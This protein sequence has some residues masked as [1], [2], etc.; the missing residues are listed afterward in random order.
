MKKAILLSVSLFITISALAQWKPVGDK[1]MSPW[2]EKVDPTNVHPE[3]PRPQMVRDQWMNLNGLWNYSITPKDAQTFTSEGKILVPF[4]VESAL[5]GVGRTVGDDNILWYEREFTVPASWKG[6]DVKL[7]FGAVDWETDVWVN[8]E[9]VGK[10]KGGFDP[11]SFNITSQLKKSGKQTLRVRVYDATDQTWQPRGKQVK[12][13]GLIWYTPVTGIW[14]TVWLEPVDRTHIEDYYIVSDVDKKTMSVDVQVAAP[15]IG[16]VVKVDIIEGG[17]GYSAENPSAKVIASA[18]TVNGKAVIT[19]PEINTWSPD[20]PYLYG[21]KVSVVRNSKVIDSVDGYTAMR[22]VSRKRDSSPCRYRRIA[23]NDQIIFQFGPLDQGWW[24][25]GLYTAPTDE[26][27][28]FDLI[29]TKEWGYN[30]VRKHIKVE[31]ARWYYYCDVLGLLVWQDMPNIA[32]HLPGSLKTRP[33]E[34]AKSQGNVWANGTFTIAGTD[35]DVPALWK[36]N[37]Y[38]EWK[39]IMMDLRCF[40]SIVMWVPFNEGWG[41]FDTEHATAYTKALDPTRMVNAASGGNLRFCGDIIDVH[42]YPAPSMNAFDKKYINVIGE[43]GGIGYPVEGHSWQDAANWG[44]GAVMTSGEA[45]LESYAMF[46]EMLSS[47]AQY[48]CAAA[49]YTQTTDVEIEVNGLMTYDRKVVKVDEAKLAEINKAV[50]AAG[51]ESR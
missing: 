12:E 34:L 19:L 48:G 41:Q 24:P 6:K 14:Q 40:Q 22:K 32:D 26:A 2:A 36:E 3:Y 44:Y 45:V 29:K 50:I 1:I 31:P 27:L 51:S 42:S 49:V 28:K 13:P 11:F 38:R 7:H 15:R 25:D 16:D 18:E 4:A 5:S 23:I 35:C 47:H 17:V 10:H 46:A 21:V 33:E 20:Q 43:Y 37:W 9:Y 30:M 39:E 8:G